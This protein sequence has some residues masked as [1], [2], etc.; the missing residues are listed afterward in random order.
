MNNI[1]GPADDWTPPAAHVEDYAKRRLRDLAEFS[2]SLRMPMVSTAVFVACLVWQ[3]GAHWGAALAWFVLVIIVREQQVSALLN[4]VDAP[5]PAMDRM[6]NAALN[7]L[8]LG[9]MHGGSALFI[10][11]IDLEYGALLTMMLMS[12]SAGAV[13]TTFMVPRGYLA[14]A[15][16]VSVPTAFAWLA[17][18]TWIGA[19]LCVLVL[20]FFNV[21]MRFAR[22][23]MH[24]YQQSYRMRLEN[25]ELLQ[26]LS[27]ERQRLA[28]ARDV[29]MEAD[30]SKSR[31]LASASHDLRQPLQ[32]LSLNSGALARMPLEGEARAIGTEIAQ[33]IESLRQM[34]DGLLDV[35]KLDAGAVTPT[36]H[37]IPLPLLMNGLCNRLQSSA[38]AK[39]LTLVCNCPVGLT[40]MS[41]GGLL[42]RVLANLLDNAMKFTEVG[43]ITLT[44]EPNG[45][46]V[47]ITVA[48]TGPGIEPADRH[49][50]F[51]DL[52]Q[53]RNPQR[54]RRMGFGLG[55]GIVRRL[56][57]I[58]SIRYD[59]ES[60]LGQGTR[61]HLWLPIGENDAVVVAESQTVLPVL[62]ARRLLVLDDD[63]DVR[64]AYAFML[65]S[66]GCQFECASTLDEAQQAL[67][68]LR[69]EVA[70][71]DFRLAGTLNGL[72]S[73]LQL[74]KAMPGLP[75]VIV[76]ADT[77]TAM[78]DDAALL[79]VPVLRKPVTDAALAAAI[80]EALHDAHQL[81]REERQ[82]EEEVRHG[83]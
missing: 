15:A 38:R 21:Q 71:V 73:I 56:S 13:S 45:A 59:I 29:A 26:E 74:R 51:E 55:L 78:R 9:L 25:L 32:S 62:V 46:T 5:Q 83:E 33:G 42:L 52:V 81:R 61:F 39:G 6:R 76:S 64:Q 31:F 44:A 3:G 80:N 54:D 40:V 10:P 63:A 14:Y 72:Q 75:A 22:Q 28:L 35:S 43:G 30:L 11:L 2:A 58:L 60:D 41:D 70:I 77:S 47:R 66:H 57:Q 23:N 1:F 37:R 19:C 24:M 79:Q 65:A 7:K 53:L 12:L 48:D 8:P 27:E 69:P 34:L 20:M 18:G 36:L 4:L 16:A 68:R 82:Q 50:I 67:P 17:T 49:R